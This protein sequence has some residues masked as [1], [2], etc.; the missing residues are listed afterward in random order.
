MKYQ[1]VESVYLR[2]VA[3]DK[4]KVTIGV[5]VKNCEN[6]LPDAVNSIIKQDF[7]H[8]LTEVLFVDDGSEDATLAVINMYLPK[9]PMRS[10]VFHHDWRG[11]GYS[12]NVVVKNAKGEYI[13]WIDGDMSIPIDFV[14]QQVE[15]MDRNPNVGIAKARYGIKQSASLVAYLQNIE[16]LVELIDTKQRSLSRPLGT[17]GS[18]YRVEAI[19]KVGGF[20]HK[21]TGVGED[22]DVEYRIGLSGWLLR[23]TMAEF[24]EKRRNNWKDLLKEYLWHGAGGRSIFNKVD[25]H[26]MLYRMFPP[27]MFVTLISRSCQAYKITSN[28][29]VFVL[30]LQW[31]FKRTA[32]LLGFTM[33]IPR[34]SN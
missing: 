21:L 9:M 22:M 18:I 5:V 28:K 8:E 4:T 14:S 12:R 32:W 30:P 31:I 26:S 15:F 1:H 33:N 10:R 17:G 27:T 29:V 25:P 19:R 13:I 11:L 23:V 2:V 3:L 20:D 34:A 16:A 24:Y 6:T 7:L